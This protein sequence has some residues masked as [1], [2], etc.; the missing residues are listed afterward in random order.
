MWPARQTTANT[1][2]AGAARGA[3]AGASHAAPEAG[4]R[5]Y[6]VSGQYM[7]PGR[8]KTPGLQTHS[9][10]GDRP[11]VPRKGFAPLQRCSP[12]AVPKAVFVKTPGNTVV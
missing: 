12:C 6:I 10:H 1:D 4:A 9:F 7:S 11:S 5:E 8:R 3:V 2:A